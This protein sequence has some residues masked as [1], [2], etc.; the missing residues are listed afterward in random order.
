MKKPEENNP[1]KILVVEDDE[2]QLYVIRKILTDEGFSVHGVIKGY[3]AINYIMEFP[4]ALML[5][6]YALP[7]IN[8][9]Q[10][11]ESLLQLH[12]Q[13]D[14]ITMTAY[15][16]EHV[17]VEMMKLGAR[18][19]LVK[20]H[21]FLKFLPRVVENT[22]NEILTERRL[23]EYQEAYREAQERYYDLFE[24]SQDAV[25]FTSIEGEI[26]AFNQS[27]VKLFAYNEE[28]LRNLN[29]R[30]LYKN[31]EDRKIFHELIMKQGWVKNFETELLDKNGDTLHVNLTT[32]LRKSKTG[33]VVGYNGIIHD[34]T[35]RKI[36]EQ[37]LSESEKRY[38]N[39]F[40]HIPIG[41]YRTTPE[42][43]ILDAN[44]ALLS[45]L[46]CPDVNALIN[47]K[48]SDFYLEPHERRKWMELIQLKGVISFE[49][50]LKT[51]DGRIIWVNDNARALTDENGDII[52]YEGV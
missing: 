25:Y 10:V 4:N 36:A 52:Y 8:G 1:F 23:K 49:T 51:F 39:L 33:K 28:E 32:T 16:N 18:D 22:V 40:E 19:Y 43:T 41:V 17:A 5:L 42:G 48:G 47:H 45:I 38:R 3:D 12:N 11:I 29:S 34:L 24:N 7:D 26:L 46:G 21:N 30:K 6:D 31:P 14:F 35:D 2:E 44:P 50:R 13:V 27:M 15:G 9:L 20:D 37:K